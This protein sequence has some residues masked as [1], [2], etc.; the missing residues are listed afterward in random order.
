M[1]LWVIIFEWMHTAKA[2][3]PNLNLFQPFPSIFGGFS[4]NMGKLFEQ[5]NSRNETGELFLIR[6]LQ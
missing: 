6:H 2:E 5:T 4:A 1:I 3:P